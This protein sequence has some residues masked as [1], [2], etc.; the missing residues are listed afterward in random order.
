MCGFIGIFNKTFDINFD[1][2]VPLI[3]HRGPDEIGYFKDE[4]CSLYSSR[5]AIRD[6]NSGQQPYTKNI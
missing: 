1:K 6:I 2:V 4:N 5:L 3:L